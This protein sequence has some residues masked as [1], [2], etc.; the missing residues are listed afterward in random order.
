MITLKT[1]I[2][3]A[4]FLM[5]TVCASGQTSEKKVKAIQ[6]EKKDSLTRF[7]D[8]NRKSYLTNQSISDLSKSDSASIAKT[9]TLI[10]Y[11]DRSIVVKNN[12]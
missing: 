5:L 3:C 2:L 8:A 6:P 4:A 1:R 7:L 12:R 9:T 10:L 11:S